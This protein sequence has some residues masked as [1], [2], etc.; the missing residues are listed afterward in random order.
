MFRTLRRSAAVLLWAAVALLPLRGLA[1]AAMPALMP[2]MGSAAEASVASMPA[3]Q[4]MPCHGDAARDSAHD[5]A[6]PAAAPGA[7]EWG[8]CPSCS[9]CALCHGGLAQAPQVRLA[10][11]S[12]QGERPAA[13]PWTVRAPR[14][15]DSLFRPPR[16]HLA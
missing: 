11:T 6:H 7:A 16:S 12:P 15:P 9:L 1:A 5:D 14:A 3:S 2:A 8:D 13:H 10:L 4:A